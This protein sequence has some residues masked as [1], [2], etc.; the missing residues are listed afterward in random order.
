MIDRFYI[1]I[2]ALNALHEVRMKYRWE[3]FDTEND[4][5]EHE[6]LICKI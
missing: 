4:A 3:A 2:L 1:Q 5:I 6:G